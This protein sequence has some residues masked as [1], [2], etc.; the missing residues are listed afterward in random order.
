LPG[1]NA[2]NPIPAPAAAERARARAECQAGLL[3]L[4]SHA[5][6]QNMRE[7]WRLNEASVHEGWRSRSQHHQQQISNLQLQIQIMEQL[8]ARDSTLPA[9]KAQ[10]IAL[11]RVQLEAPPAR[12]PMPEIRPPPP[13]P[14]ATVVAAAVAPTAAVPAASAPAAARRLRQRLNPDEHEDEPEDPLVALMR[15]FTEVELGGDGDCL[16]FVFRYLQDH[17]IGHALLGQLGVVI[18]EDVDDTRQ[19]VAAH[20]QSV[21]ASISDG[22]GVPLADAMRIEMGSHDEYITGLRSGMCGGQIEVHA[23]AHLMQV[24]VHLHS[25]TPFGGDIY[26][27]VA[28][29]DANDSEQKIFH[30]LHIV[31]RGGSGGHYR[32]LLPTRIPRAPSVTCASRDGS[33][34]ITG[35]AAAPTSRL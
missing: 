10:L 9:L 20:L 4:S 7:A 22:S 2:S 5:D 17:E 6:T 28:N 12:Q 15:R 13:P 21:S 8:D 32:L 3:L 29:A 11:C 33:V 27:E 26:E 19:R 31:G 23:W 25:T 35:G 14:A 34:D 16:F 1:S 24:C 18:G 30:V